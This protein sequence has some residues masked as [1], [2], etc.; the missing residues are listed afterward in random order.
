MSP[1]SQQTKFQKVED[2]FRRKKVLVA[3]SGGVD[4][5]V[6]A[7][8]AK[9]SAKEVLLLTVETQT[10][11]RSEM[12]HATAVAEELRLDL[13]RIEYDWL[14][15]DT[16]SNNTRDRCYRCKKKLGQL[17]LDVAMERSLD[18]VVEGTTVSDL[19]GHRPG[20][21]ALRELGI[22]SPLLDEGITKE[23]VRAYAKSV[24]L[25]VADRPSMACLATRFPYDTKITKK[26][27][28]KVLRIEEFVKKSFGMRVVRARLHDNLIRIEVGTDDREKLFDVGLLDELYQYVTSIGV[29]FVAI[30]VKGYRAGAMDEN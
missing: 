9:H 1:S 26:M 25:S 24:G 11:T 17:W 2:K 4:S 6:I 22:E 10:F 5:S 14:A 3:F 13:V 29:P 19:D 8:I 12:N 21:R 28:D 18:M 15:D 23:E 7:A 16:L 20:E 27:L 30:D